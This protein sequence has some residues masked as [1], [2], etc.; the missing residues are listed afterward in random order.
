MSS[1]FIGNEGYKYTDSALARQPGPLLLLLLLFVEVEVSISL[2]IMT[3][4]LGS[5]KCCE[6][7]TSA[8][9]SALD[10]SILTKTRADGST[11]SEV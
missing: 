1:S 8:S 6:C 4:A 10:F 3:K 2:L 9:W 7:F 5:V 11:P